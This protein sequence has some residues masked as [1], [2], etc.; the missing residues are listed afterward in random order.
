MRPRHPLLFLLSALM[1]TP[2]SAQDADGD[3]PADPDTA[4]EISTASPALP[5]A[6]TPAPAIRRENLI[7][8][9]PFRIRV[10]RRDTTTAPQALEIRGFMGSGRN[11]EISLSNPN[12]LEC[13]WVRVGDPD[14]RWFVESADPVTRTASVRMDG[15][16]I[17]V[18]MA[19]PA[20]LPPPAPPAMPTLAGVGNAPHSV[21]PLPA[22]TSARPV[23]SANAGGL[24]PAAGTPPPRRSGFTDPASAGAAS[25]GRRGSRSATANSAGG[26]EVTESRANRAFSR[27][28]NAVR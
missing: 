11:L 21:P 7:N 28:A 13:Q 24:A 4:T 6:D 16:T 10:P 17:S 2:L 25:T 15:M 20:E 14:A 9:S 8:N 26:S 3:T 18:H 12:T 19:K 27:P 1:A 22:V 23:L 5:H